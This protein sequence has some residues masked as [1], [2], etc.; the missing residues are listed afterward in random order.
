MADYAVPLVSF[1]CFFKFFQEASGVLSQ[2]H[3]IFMWLLL[4]IT[5]NMNTK[6]LYWTENPAAQNIMKQFNELGVDV[7]IFETEKDFLYLEKEDVPE[8][9]L[10]IIPS[11]H[12]SVANKK[13]LTIHATGNFGNADYGGEPKKLNPT[14]PSA[15]AV[16]LRSMAKAQLPGFEVCLEVTHHGP[17]LKTPLVFIEIGSTEKEWKDEEAGKI[18]ANAVKDILENTKT[19]TNCIGFGGPHYAPGFSTLILENPNIA[20]GHILPK[21]QQENV[22]KEIIQQMIEG[23]NATKAVFD[24]DGMKGEY[25]NK[26]VEI[27]EELGINWRKTGE[28]H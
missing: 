7:P 13:S 9:D 17:T 2:S 20:F 3:N 27:I 18:V 14:D 24:W 12:K 5:V 1:F 23:S 11:T 25:R 26:A 10:L 6:I 8:A 19:F 16:G 15:I 28:L 21:Y 22:S 4:Y